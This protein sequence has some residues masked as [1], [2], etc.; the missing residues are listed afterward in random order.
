M[1][2]KT[3]RP[4]RTA[5]EEEESMQRTLTDVRGFRAW[6]A[7]SGVKSK[8][9]DIA[10]IYSEVPASAAALFTQNVVVAEPI[11]LSRRHI[12][13][14]RAQAFVINAGNAN[15]CTGEQGRRG[16]EAMADATAEALGIDREVVLV[17][18]TGIIGRTFPTENVVNGIKTC[19]LKLSEL[20]LAG[21]LAANAILTT[22]TFAKESFST[23]R[24]GGKRVHM[25]G[26]AKGS[27][28][29]HPEMA[30]MLAF[31]VS[32][33]AISRELLDEALREAV[34]DSFNMITVDGD[35]STND[36][37]AV[38]CNGLAGN[39]QI[40][41]KGLIYDTFRAE[42]K[43]HCTELAR[44]IV[45]DGEGATK[46]IQYDV[47]GAP[48]RNAARKIARTVSNSNLV[49]TAIFG[50]DPNWGRIVAAAGRAGIRYDPDK[51][52]LYIGTSKT[53]IKLLENGQPLDVQRRK[54]KSLMRAAYIY[55]L[56][57]LH[58]GEARATAWGA[59][60][61]YEYVRIN[62]EYST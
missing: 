18:S 13:S 36:M 43:S 46:L 50:R 57:D 39:E 10:L 44:Q 9:R 34:D 16:A 6:G 2:E 25:G 14:G 1:K 27:G 37:V 5:S 52:D 33:V 38:M 58:Q 4:K 49:K 24:I 59:D 23:T 42:L 45:S 48:D 60:F 40:R 41:E 55:V 3:R 47:E 17:A 29:I 11:K 56:L 8:R 7:Y 35:T 31:I 32:D 30:T 12:R 20:R 61:S 62:A 26:I 28:M 51:V 15:A 19:A 54:L 22:D 53:L 21:T